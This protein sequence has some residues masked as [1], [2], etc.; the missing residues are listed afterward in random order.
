MCNF[1]SFVL[2]KDSVFYLP[3][4]ESHTRIISTHGIV[5]SGAKGL[6][7]VKVEILPPKGVIALDNISDWKV[8]FDQDTFPEW[9][10]PEKSARRARSLLHEK[11]TNL[12]TLYARGSQIVDVSALTNLQTLDAR[13]SQIVDVSALTNLQTM[14]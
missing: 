4:S 8:I 6:N 13:G 11:L 14:V 5:E 12:Q 7:V 3:D 2:T 1:A 10:D 9:H